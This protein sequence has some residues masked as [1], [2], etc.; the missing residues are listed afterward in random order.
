MESEKTAQGAILAPSPSSSFS[1]V[2]FPIVV[3]FKETDWY[4]HL[5]KTFAGVRPR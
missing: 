2:Q 5:S 4:E 3:S 1:D